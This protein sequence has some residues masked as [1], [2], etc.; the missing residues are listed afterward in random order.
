MRPYPIRPPSEDRTVASNWRA[1][2]RRTLRNIDSSREDLQRQIILGVIEHLAELISSCGVGEAPDNAYQIY[3]HAADKLGS[4]FTA[5][6]KLN[7]M[8]GESV[9]SDDLMVSVIGG[10]HPFDGEHMEDAYA[11]GKGNP[12]QCAVVCTT[13]L[14][15]CEMDGL[16][17][18][19]VLLKPKVALRSL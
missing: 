8:I 7:K 9:V 14:G 5:A 11:Q 6:Q 17:A 16:R 15:L 4:L 2:T 1:L 12:I 19:K 13:D 10:G 3:K 18:G